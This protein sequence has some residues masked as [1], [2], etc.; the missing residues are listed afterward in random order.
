MSW[1]GLQPVPCKQP[2]VKPA[3]PTEEELKAKAAARKAKKQRQK[4]I[5]QQ[6]KA[7]KPQLQ[8]AHRDDQA[9]ADLMQ[10][11][12][13]AEQ[14]QQ[15]QDANNQCDH[16]TQLGQ[17][18]LVQHQQPP[19]TSGPQASPSEDAALCSGLPAMQTDVCSRDA[20]GAVVQQ[21][22]EPGPTSPQP[23]SNPAAH[24]NTCSPD[25]NLP[26]LDGKCALECSQVQTDTQQAE[27]SASHLDSDDAFL[28]QMVCCPITQVGHVML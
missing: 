5:K 26:Q 9:D 20:A 6:Q 17:D 18:V 14:A 19:S 12:G 3:G 7:S 8:Q 11:A 25:G 27:K 16:D 15:N 24:Q 13:E 22:Q 2:A 28:Q 4:A 10:H 1:Q 21:G 23:S